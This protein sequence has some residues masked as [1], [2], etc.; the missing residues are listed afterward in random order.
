[1]S[2][3]HSINFNIDSNW[4]CVWSMYP[5]FENGDII[6]IIKPKT[7][8]IFAGMGSLYQH[9]VFAHNGRFENSGTNVQTHTNQQSKC[10]T[11][12]GMSGISGSCTASSSNT[13]TQGG[14]VVQSPP[15]P[16]FS[17]YAHFASNSFN[18][19]SDSY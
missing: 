3:H 10:Q 19:N 12:S 5:C 16:S 1:M 8:T 14:G 17:I 9:V 6:N 4:Y 2:K 11:A 13:I 7:S 15:Q 18:V